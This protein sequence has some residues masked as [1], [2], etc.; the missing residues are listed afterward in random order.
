MKRKFPTD[1]V[2]AFELA[3]KLLRLADVPVSTLSSTEVPVTTEGDTTE[4][5]AGL[6]KAKVRFAELKSVASL[7]IRRYEELLD[8][9]KQRQAGDVSVWKKTSVENADFQNNNVKVARADSVRMSVD[10]NLISACFEEHVRA[11]QALVNLNV[12]RKVTFTGGMAK[13]RDLLQSGH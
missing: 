3:H 11:L 7:N 9:A 2:E 4:L 1:V 12:E 5:V 10:M 6:D 13:I 8:E